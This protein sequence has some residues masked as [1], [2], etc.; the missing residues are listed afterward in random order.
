MRCLQVFFLV[1]YAAATFPFL[2]G[3]N[4]EQFA[5]RLSHDSMKDLRPVNGRLHSTTTPT[6]RSVPTAPRAKIL[7]SWEQDGYQ[8]A[9]IPRGSAGN[10]TRSGVTSDRKRT[11]ES[12]DSLGPRRGLLDCR[13]LIE[14]FGS[15]EV[16]EITCIPS[17]RAHLLHPCY[18][19]IWRLMKEE[20]CEGGYVEADI[21]GRLVDSSDQEV[22][23]AARK[24]AGANIADINASQPSSLRNMP[25]ADTI[26]GK[27]LD[28]ISGAQLITPKKDSTTNQQRSGQSECETKAFLMARTCSTSDALVKEE[29]KENCKVCYPTANHKRICAHCAR[30]RKQIKASSAALSATIVIAAALLALLR[31]MGQQRAGEKSIGN[32]DMTGVGNHPKLATPVRRAL[33]SRTLAKLRRA[34]ITLLLNRGQPSGPENIFDKT[35]QRPVSSSNTFTSSWNLNTG[36]ILLTRDPRRDLFNLEP[37]GSE[38]EERKQADERDDHESRRQCELVGLMSERIPVLP[39]APNASIRLRGNSERQMGN[40]TGIL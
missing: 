16:K 37:S 35:L 13:A 22:P 33:P 6:K 27:P 40:T 25:G 23:G 24:T 12:D 31:R 8:H 5:L 2:R 17:S 14:S 11:V 1:C 38:R 32:L 26:L 19:S 21:Q 29:T 30:K 20:R 3:T 34:E 28:N 9:V 18:M 36:N 10:D 39:R 4:E 15:L 7:S